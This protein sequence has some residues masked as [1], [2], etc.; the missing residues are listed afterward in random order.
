MI[1]KTLSHLV[2]PVLATAAL[3]VSVGPAP[4]QRGGHGGGFHAG[5]FHGGGYHGGYGGYHYGYHPG[6]GYHGY[7]PYYNGY[8]VYPHYGYGYYPYYFGGWSYPYYG[9]GSYPYSSSSGYY[10]PDSS[11]APSDPDSLSTQAPDTGGNSAASPPSGASAGSVVRITVRLP[12]Q[13]QL[14]FD[15][16]KTT[17]TG[18]VREFTTPPLAPGRKYRYEVRARWVDNATTMDQKQ[19][20][21]FAPGG[22]AEVSFPAGSAE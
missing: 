7:H 22:N 17:A 10:A 8:H 16:T 20:I 11:D 4:A 3:L 9:S 18:P 12:D 13:A 21:V 1:R 14:W 2:L 19:T 5:G 15:G 6:Y